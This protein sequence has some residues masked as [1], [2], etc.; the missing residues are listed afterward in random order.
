M[1][2][3]IAAIAYVVVFALVAAIAFS[4]L[5]ALATEDQSSRIGS[6]A[7]F[8]VGF[9][10]WVTILVLPAYF[11][12]FAWRRFG[13]APVRGKL[14]T[15]RAALAALFLSLALAAILQ[16]YDC[17]AGGP[18]QCPTWAVHLLAYT[19]VL[20]TPALLCVWVANS[21]AKQWRATL[22]G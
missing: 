15:R 12:A 16:V 22:G 4:A 2:T 8:V 5:M 14:V 10:G 13:K 18:R 3:F 11:A 9:F 7:E 20:Y 6:F 1:K 19:A 17:L 21:A